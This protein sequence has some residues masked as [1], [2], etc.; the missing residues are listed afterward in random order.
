MDFSNLVTWALLAGI[1]VAIVFFLSS[2]NPE[3][4]LL[5]LEEIGRAAKGLMSP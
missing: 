2:D 1:G 5:R 3:L 4:F